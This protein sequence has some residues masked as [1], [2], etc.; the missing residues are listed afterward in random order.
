[1]NI[2]LFH[3]VLTFNSVYILL[4][5]IVEYLQN[6]ALA[7]LVS[8]L[9]VLLV[10][11]LI[12]LNWKV[13]N[14]M[15]LSVSELILL[16]CLFVGCSFNIIFSPNFELAN[17]IKFIFIFLIFLLAKNGIKRNG[18]I[19]F[20]LCIFPLIVFPIICFFQYIYDSKILGETTKAVLF[21][22]NRNN[23]IAYT[24]VCIFVITALTNKL[25]K[26][27]LV[28]TIV[29]LFYGTLGAFVAFLFSYFVVVFK[30]NAKAW[31]KLL[32]LSL[33]FILLFVYSEL[34]IIDRVRTVVMGVVNFFEI[35]SFSDLK[36]IDFG[37]IVL[38]QEG[39]KDVSLFFRLKHWGEIIAIM[40]EN[41][42]YFFSGWGMGASVTLTSM[43]LV[44]HNDWLR[45]LFE[46]GVFNFVAFLILN[47]H[48][49]SKLKKYDKFLSVLFLTLCVYMFSENLIN[50]FLIISLLYFTS[51]LLI[52]NENF[53]CRT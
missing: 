38:L 17:F 10:A 2:S 34:A 8:L 15:S 7:F 13:I 45:V 50:N 25:K 43:E 31:L 47:Y 23:A 29:I 36:R 1:M 6:D 48:I 41:Y 27:F 33:A 44:P 30:W 3:K 32:F 28:T 22:S 35:Y 42:W 18:P 52:K 14:R 24:L 4:L 5:L 40:L 9:P 51:G 11:F 49:F 37:Q 12:L 46:L 16:I 19:N 39:S 26:T 20:K 21:F 53:K